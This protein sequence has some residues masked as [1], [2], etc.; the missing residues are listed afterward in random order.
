MNGSWKEKNKKNNTE[1]KEEQNDNYKSSIRRHRF[2]PPRK[3]YIHKRT[4][5]QRAANNFNC[6]RIYWNK[7][8]ADQKNLPEQ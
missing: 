6:V 5:N 7:T 2:L 4:G 1:G 3:W 8:Y